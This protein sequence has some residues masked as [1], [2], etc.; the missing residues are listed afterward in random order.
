MN[1]TAEIILIMNPTTNFGYV[2][3]VVKGSIL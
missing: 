1:P 2:E 3:L